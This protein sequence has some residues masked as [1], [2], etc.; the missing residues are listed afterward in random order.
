MTMQA[1]L[2]VEDDANLRE[3]LFDTLSS[4]DQPVLTADNG[5]QA[6]EILDSTSVGLVVSD[7]RMEPMDGLTLLSRIRESHPTLPAVLDDSPRYDREC[8]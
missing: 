5:H 8:G 1:V 6:L 7:W 3:A 4:D 2:I